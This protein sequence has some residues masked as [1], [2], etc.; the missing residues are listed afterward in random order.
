MKMGE[1]TLFSF[2]L[3]CCEGL[4]DVATRVLK[5]EVCA[6]RTKK[7]K[8]LTKKKKKKT[9]GWTGLFRGLVPRVAKITPAS[10]VMLSCFEM[11]RRD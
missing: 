9:K 2:F 1:I 6:Q 11:L 4:I 8:C 3:T 10:A 5:K 7:K